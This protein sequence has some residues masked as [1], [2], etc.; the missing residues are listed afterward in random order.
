MNETL[1]SGP[2]FGPASGGAPR[3]LI[4]FLHGRG[5]DGDDL[6]GLAPIFAKEFPDAL[7]L[8]PHAPQSC[9]DVPFGLQWFSRVDW[10]PENIAAGV[11]GAAPAI[12]AFLDHHLAAHGLDDSNLALFGFSQGCMMALHVGLRRRAAP[13]AILGFSRPPRAS[14][15]KSRPGRLFFLCM[16]T[17]MWW[18]PMNRSALPSRP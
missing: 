15:R 7:F 8:S 13:A 11:R 5:A 3:Q 18:C 14:P 16:A 2:S 1:L 17:P 9:D 6:I 4:V 10:V 12:D